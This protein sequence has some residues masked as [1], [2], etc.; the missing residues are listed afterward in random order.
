MSI[1]NLPAEAPGA[2]LL[3]S[4]GI[5]ALVG[6]LFGGAKGAATGALIGGGA[7]LAAVGVST[8]VSSPATSQAAQGMFN[9]LAMSALSAK[10]LPRVPR[11]AAPAR[12]V[13]LLPADADDEAKSRRPRRAASKK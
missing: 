8:A 5:G 1:A 7:G 10:P 3:L 2:T 9:G 6:A 11:L 13:A 4:T 12:P